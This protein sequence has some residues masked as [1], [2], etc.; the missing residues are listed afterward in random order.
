VN[1]A[2]TT[3]SVGYETEDYVITVAGPPA[4]IQPSGFSVSNL[5]SGGATINWATVTGASGYEW[6]ISTSA[7]Q[8]TSGTPISG[9]S[10]VVSGL[11]PSTVYYFF[12]RTD[13]GTNGYSLWSSYAFATAAINNDPWNAIPITVGATCT[14]NPYTTIG[15]SQDAAEPWPSCAGT[16]G[17]YSVWYSF[18]APASGAVK[19]SNDFAGGTLG[20]PRLALYSTSNVNSYASY[21]ILACDDDNGVTVGTNSILYATGLTPSNTYYLQVDV[22][23]AVAQASSSISGTFCLEVRELTSTMLAS[24]GSCAAGQGFSRNAGY[25]AASS[26]CDGSGNLIAIVTDTAGTSA[27]YSV[28]MT[29]N[30]AAVRQTG[31]QYYLDRN[32]LING[33]TSGNIFLQLFFTTAELT[34][35]QGVVPSATLANLNVTRQT[36]TTCQAAFSPTGGTNTGLNQIGNSSVNNANW[37]TVVTPGFS[38]FYIQSGAVPL[39]IQLPISEAKTGLTGKQNARCMVINLNWKEAQTVRNSATW[40][41]STLRVDL[42]PIAI[43]T[44]LHLR[45]S[46]ITV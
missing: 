27:T 39:A 42:L 32:F 28:S 30:T 14:G 41:L 44:K 18:V 20:D 19:I 10:A 13:C 35:L 36:G 25:R 23:D 21:T 11:N 40:R 7:T 17:Y 3:I 31:N 37:I 24:S 38:N 15:G 2:C 33:A 12:V 8:P 29:K 34:A 43:G 46:T 1:G 22:F 5:T 16:G 26:L 4:C 45:E 9:N 6:A